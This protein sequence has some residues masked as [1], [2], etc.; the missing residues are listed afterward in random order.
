MNG[1]KKKSKNSGKSKKRSASNNKRT[2]P[3]YVPKSNWSQNNNSETI[4]VVVLENKETKSN[5]EDDWGILFLAFIILTICVKFF[6]TYEDTILNIIYWIS[7][8]GFIFITVILGREIKFPSTNGLKF[9]LGWTAFLWLCLMASIH[10]IY[11]PLYLSQ[12]AIA[13]QESIK[14]GAGVLA[15]GFDGFFYLSY[16]VIGF[17][18]P[19]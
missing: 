3:N 15:R 8:L 16:Q 4:R 7:L 9:L 13:T 1:W 6:F 18:F 14:N 5:S 19:S 2:P 12:Q 17:S 11:H 10:V